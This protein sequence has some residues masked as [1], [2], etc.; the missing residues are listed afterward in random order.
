MKAFRAFVGLWLPVILWC[1]LIFYLSGIPYLRITQASW[2]LI[3]RK[4][5]HVGVFAI[6]ARLLARAFMESTT[7]SWKRIFVFSLVFTIL[8]ACTDEFHQTFVPGRVGCV[9]D[10]MIDTVGGLA[11]LGFWP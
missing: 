11:A 6:L 8:Y 7:W 5:A 9:H 4:I 10:V 2:D 1:A 3:A